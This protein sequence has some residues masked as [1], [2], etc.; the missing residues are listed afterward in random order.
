VVSDY[1]FKVGDVVFYRPSQKGLGLSANN[2]S[3]EVP[4][5]GKALGITE[6]QKDFRLVVEGYSH[7][8]GGIFW[9]EFRIPS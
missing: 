3:L 5:V 7:P 2:T 1:P 8:A 9:T 6:I 4:K